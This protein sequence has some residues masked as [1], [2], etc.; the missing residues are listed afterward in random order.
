MT[1]HRR[2]Q[3]IADAKWHAGM[4]LKCCLDGGGSGDFE[5]GRT[6]EEVLLMEKTIQTIAARLISTPTVTR[7]R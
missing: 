4:M 6:E 2:R 1:K 3:L 7:G 5:D